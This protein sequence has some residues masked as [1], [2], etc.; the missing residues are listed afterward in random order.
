MKR[1]LIF[2]AAGFVG[3]YLRKELESSNYSVYGSDVKDTCK[4]F[5]DYLC[6]DILNVEKVYET[7][8][9]V[10]PDYI[11]NLAALSS[12]GL[13]WEKPVATM[14]IN[15]IGSLN[16]L[17]AIKEINKN[18]KIL[19]VGSSEEYSPC[20]EKIDEEWSLNAN[21]PYGISKLALEQFAELYRH[22]YGMKIVFVRSFNHTGIGQQDSFVIPSFC[23]QVAAIQKSGENGQI[24]VGNLSAR[25]DISDVRDIVRAY[26][27]ILE[28]DAKYTVY[29]IGSGVAY[30]MDEILTYIIQLCDYTVE[31]VVDPKR[32][33]PI[34][35]PYI[36]CNNNRIK[37]AIGWNPQYKILDTVKL[38][39]ENMVNH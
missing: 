20:S 21:N 16:I 38:M 30:S 34:D 8:R 23:K 14:E 28:K 31:I 32:V 7:I 35:N 3:E 36:C 29:N 17:E 24:H 15:T 33:R 19:L 22:K 2:G 9:E 27:M 18:C 4:S 10:Q 1:V 13:S 37:E 12:V 26:R 6:C 25:R 39:F 11:V 5:S